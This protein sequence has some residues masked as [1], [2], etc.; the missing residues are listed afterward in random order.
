MILIT[1]SWI[2][3]LISQEGGTSFRDP[4]IVQVECWGGSFKDIELSR[5]SLATAAKLAD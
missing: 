3:N 5:L 2:V 4:P 1:Q